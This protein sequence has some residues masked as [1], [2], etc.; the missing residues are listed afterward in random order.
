MSVKLKS[1]APAVL[2]LCDNDPNQ[3]RKLMEL[4]MELAMAAATTQDVFSYSQEVGAPRALGKTPA[5][6]RRPQPW[7]LLDMNCLGEGVGYRS[8][9]TKNGRGKT[10][11][12]STEAIE[13]LKNYW[14]LTKKPK[15][16]SARLRHD[17]QCRSGL[18]PTP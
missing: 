16:L 15:A 4:T 11:D 7:L 18:P 6:F 14:Q 12:Y 8:R 5:G 13:F 9:P 17:R 2:H 1:F 3:I 10:R